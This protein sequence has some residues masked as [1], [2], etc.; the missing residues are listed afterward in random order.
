MLLVILGRCVVDGGR[1]IVMVVRG[2]GGGYVGEEGIDAS[3]SV[4]YTVVNIM[5]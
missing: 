3:D 1:S 5:L 2:S 4:I